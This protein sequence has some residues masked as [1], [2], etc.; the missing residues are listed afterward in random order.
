MGR[1]EEVT[2]DLEEYRSLWIDHA[3]VEQTRK[4]IIAQKI[5]NGSDCKFAS[6]LIHEEE[7]PDGWSL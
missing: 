7:L 5:E 6:V 4:R 1:D 3:F 2:I